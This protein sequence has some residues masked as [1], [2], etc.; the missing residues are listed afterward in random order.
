MVF[1]R[2]SVSLSPSDPLMDIVMVIRVNCGG[3]R[4]SE[5]VSGGGEG[6]KK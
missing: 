4:F 1:P 2:L 6:I 5:T 3:G